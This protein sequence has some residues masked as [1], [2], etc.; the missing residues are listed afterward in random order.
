MI[1]SKLMIFF[2][3]Y[4]IIT[5]K[6]RGIEQM[7]II[8]KAPAKIN[9]GFDVLSKRTD[10]YH[11]VETIMTSIDLADYLTFSLRDD[12]KIVI[13]TENSF[14]PLDENN[15]IYQACQL[16]RE[17]SKMTFGVTI[18]L[19]KRIPV[20]AGLAGGSSDAAATLRGLNRLLNL[21]YSIEELTRLGSQIGSDVPYCLI[22][23]TVLATDIGTSI[24][25]I[26]NVPACWVVVVKPAVSIS[27][28][29]IFKEINLDGITHPH[30][31]RLLE[32]IEQ[33]DYK[34]MCSYM[35]NALEH[36]TSKHC[37]QIHSIRRCLLKLGAD[38]VV[39][40]GTGPTMLGFFQNR[41]KAEKIINGLKGFCN[42]VYLVRTI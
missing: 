14:L 10:G 22:G 15:H 23:G 19:R 27:T 31:A 39:M 34:Q 42:E 24:K 32:A 9:L 30:I 11:N 4:C 29:R 13:E 35:D 1:N 20:A 6:S 2:I 12:Q 7:E 17:H 36:I 28:K 5:L 38:S 3:N 33:K 41:R 21:N 16:I 40:T 8:E 18:K 37:P 25:V 26:T